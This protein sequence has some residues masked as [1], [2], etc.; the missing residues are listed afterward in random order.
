MPR[1]D[2]IE[3]RIWMVAV[4]MVGQVQVE[5]L[6][7]VVVVAKRVARAG[8]GISAIQMVVVVVLAVWRQLVVVLIKLISTGQLAE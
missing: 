5:R 3:M 2:E 8:E 4:L 7:L 6:V 1:V